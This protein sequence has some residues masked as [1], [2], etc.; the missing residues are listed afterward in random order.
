MVLCLSPSLS[1]VK[2]NMRQNNVDNVNRN[3]KQVR[4]QVK[5]EE[6]KKWLIKPYVMEILHITLHNL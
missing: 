3:G 2:L 5:F 4:K 1:F 6:A